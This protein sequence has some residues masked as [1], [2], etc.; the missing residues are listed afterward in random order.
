MSAPQS[1]FQWFQ[2]TG[3]II[4]NEEKNKFAMSMRRQSFPRKKKTFLK[5]VKGKWNFQ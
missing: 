2:A 1:S 3:H 4:I 5:K